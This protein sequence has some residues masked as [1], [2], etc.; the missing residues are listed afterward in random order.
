GNDD[1]IRAIHMYCDLFSGAV[2]DGIQAEM[3]RAGVDIGESEAPTEEISAAEGAVPE[4]AP[5]SEAV[6]AEEQPGA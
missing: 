2:L 5:A 4:V 3:T 1:A 6:V